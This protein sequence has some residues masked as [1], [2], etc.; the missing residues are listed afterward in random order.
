M[1]TKSKSEIRARLV[2]SN[3]LKPSG[4]FL[5]DRPKVVLLLQIIFVVCV[6]FLC[7]YVL[8]IPCSLAITCYRAD[9]L[10]VFFVMFPCV[11][12]TFS[13]G[14]LDEVWYSIEL[15]S[16]LCPIPVTIGYSHPRARP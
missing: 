7:H 8:S 2:L 5:I 9:F 3:I 10:N 1:Q 13:Y 4:S 15:V 6:L 11:F 16:D 14:V 12:V